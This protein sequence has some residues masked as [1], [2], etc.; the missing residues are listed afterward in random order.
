M[1]DKLDRFTKRARHVLTLAQETAL[2]LH[3]NTIS[4][5]HLLLGL[6][7][8]EDC[9]AVTVLHKLGVEPGQIISAV[10]RTVDQGQ[11]PLQGKPKLGENTKR[12]IEFSIDE[13]RLMGH[14]Y[15][16]TEHLLLGIIR[17]GESM[18]VNV[19]Q[20]QGISLDNVRAR[21]THVIQQRQAQEKKTPPE[22][23]SGQSATSKGDDVE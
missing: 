23:E 14:H 10:E 12:I 2:R 19:L 22:S 15:I 13:M 20:E 18:A 3:H 5:E 9:T 21:T 4:P 1:P 16:G 11:T 17:Q 6:A 7:R 8:E